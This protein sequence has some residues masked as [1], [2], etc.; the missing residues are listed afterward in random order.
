MQAFESV[1]EM[2]AAFQKFGTLSDDS[3]S[4]KD[5]DGL[6]ANLIDNLAFSAVFGSDDVKSAARWLVWEIS[7]EV[8]SPA[9]SIH[10]YY[11]AGGR[12]EWAHRTTPA[13]NVR[14]M[15]YDVVRTALQ[16]AHKLDVGQI[17]FEIARSEIGYTEQEPEEYATSVLAAAIRQGHQGPVFIQGDHF[18]INAKN[19]AQDPEKELQGV[20]DVITQGLAAGFYNIDV[21]CSTIVDLSLEGEEAQQAENALRTAELTAFIREREPEEITVSVGGEIGEVGTKN[22]TVAELRAFMNAYLRDLAQI[23]ES[24][25]GISKISVQTGTS[26]GGVPLPDGTVAQVSVDFETLAELSR[27]AREEYGLAG[28]VQHG[29]STLPEEAFKLFAD[30]NACEVHLATG[31]QNIIFDSPSLPVELKETVYA[32]LA[33]NRASERKPDMTDAQFY[34]TTRKRGFGPFKK[35]FWTLPEEVKNAINTELRD[36]FELIFDR[37]G[38]ANTSEDVNALTPTPRIRKERPAS[39]REAFVAGD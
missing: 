28:A 26:H 31:F 3:I 33:E 9:A 17:I 32:W 5:A 35:E 16:A 30:A 20:R 37:L 24:L 23:D 19:Y 6:R 21:D 2:L 13:I 29:A 22:S 12:G 25:D 11:M 10:D 36:R 34:Y 15:T 4:V 14:G 8:G 39:I 27:V 7:Q 1:R 18:Q 38:V